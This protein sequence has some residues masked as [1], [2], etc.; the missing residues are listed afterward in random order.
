MG[1]L[2]VRVLPGVMAASVALTVA[3]VLFVPYVARQYRRRGRLGVGH[4]AL[5]FAFL[6]YVLALV[7][8]VLVPMPPLVP[9]FCSYHGGQRPQLEALG[10]LRGLPGVHATG[11]LRAV[12]TDADFQQFA[13]NIALFVPLGMFLRHMFRRGVVATLAIGVATTLFVEFTQL[14]GN[15]FVYPCPYR[16]FDVDDLIANA[17]GTGVGVVLAPLL[18]L[19]PGQR[20][21]PDPGAPRP[22]TAGRRLLGMLCDLLLMWLGGNLAL[23]PVEWALRTAAPLADSGWMVLLPALTPWSLPALVVLLVLLPTGGTP[24]QH[25]VMLRF[26]RV[27]RRR[28]GAG[29]LLVAWLVG[30]GGLGVLAAAALA[31]WA[32]GAPLALGLAALHVVALVLVPGGRGMT[33][34]LSGLHTVDSRPARPAGR[35]ETPEAHVTGPGGS[36]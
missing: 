28:P 20:A 36:T 4:A 25:V 29:R 34:L 31:G 10:S 1:E 9:D 12:V 8:Y 16:L 18:R 14:T 35:A 15:W 5:A 13:M 6:V 32:P 3:I 2:G 17:V 11:G 22:V 30:L 7:A 26:H 33:G 27:G 21:V 19:V 24:G 23:L